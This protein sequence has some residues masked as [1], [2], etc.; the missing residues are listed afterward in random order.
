MEKEENGSLMTGVTNFIQK[1]R[2]PIF[3]L[4]GIIVVGLVGLAVFGILKTTGDMQATE[5]VDRASLRLEKWKSLEDTDPVKA[6]HETEAMAILKPFLDN[7]SSAAAGDKALFLASQI[8]EEKGNIEEQ[9]NLLNKI[10]ELFPSSFRKIEVSLKLVSIYQKQGKVSE[11][12]I[13]LDK[14]LADTTVPGFFKEEILFQ[15]GS[16]VETSD[17]TK[18]LEYY[19]EL[20]DLYP[21]SDWTKLARSRI[22][23]LELTT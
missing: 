20:V 12:F 19:K 3:A 22:I 7:P 6:E 13:I 14:L 5:I 15:K 21:L 1:N 9:V 17:K 2:I 4:A 23:Y 8:Q 18:A 11:A 10:L 16:M